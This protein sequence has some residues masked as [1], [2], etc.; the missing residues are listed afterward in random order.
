M[1]L[2]EWKVISHKCPNHSRVGV[3]DKIDLFKYDWTVQKNFN[4]NKTSNK[5]IKSKTLTINIVNIRA[6]NVRVHYDK[7][8]HEICMSY[9]H[10]FSI[11]CIKTDQNIHYTQYNKLQTWFPFK[12]FEAKWKKRLLWKSPKNGGGFTAQPSNF[13]SAMF[14]AIWSRA[15]KRSSL[16]WHFLFLLWMDISPQ[17]KFTAYWSWG[18]SLFF[19]FSGGVLSWKNDIILVVS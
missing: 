6:R 5:T 11:G 12:T 1:G 9:N 7:R 16:N 13:F 2:K 4:V 17:K 8:A 14:V 19:T 18:K 10:I 3:I 15:L